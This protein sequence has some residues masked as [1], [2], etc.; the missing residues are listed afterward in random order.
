MFSKYGTPSEVTVPAL[1]PKKIIEGA[2]G[3]RRRARSATGFSCLP[4]NG[5]ASHEELTMIANIFLRDSF[6]NGL[7]AFKLSAGIE[8]PAVLT[9]PQVG[10]TFETLAFELNINRRWN[11][12]TT[13]RAAQ[14]FLKSGHMHCTRNVPVGTFG[15]SFWLLSRLFTTAVPNGVALHVTTLAVLSSHG[16]ESPQA[17]LAVF[18]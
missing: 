3:V 2:S 16:E 10:F 7:G 5:R 6:G 14:H 9:G 4:L 15:C 8:V 12:R 17:I 13:E 11:D 1:L 18:L